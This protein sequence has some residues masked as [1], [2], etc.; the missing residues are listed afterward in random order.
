MNNKNRLS[1]IYGNMKDRCCNPNSPSYKYYGGRGIMICNEWLNKEIVKYPST[2]GWLAFEKWSLENGYKDNLTIDRID[3]NKGYSP[4][5]CR[6]VSMKEQ[7]NNTRRNI[8]IDYQG[9]SKTLAEWCDELELPYSEIHLRIYK[10]H[11]SINDA[12]EKPLK[13]Y[14]NYRE[15]NYRGKKQSLVKWCNE[16]NLDYITIYHRIVYLKWTPEKAFETTKC[17]IRKIE[18]KGKTQS[19]MKWCNELNLNYKTIYKRVVNLEWAI[20]RAFE[21]RAGVNKND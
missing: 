5:N 3:T 17:Y 14:S 19:L 13:K 16:L 11:W 7:S 9:K 12:F 2:K 4:D 10:C 8:R 1:R 18:Y 20:E 6:W 15:I 21:T